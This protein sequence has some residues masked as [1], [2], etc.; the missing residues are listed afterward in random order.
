MVSHTTYDTDFV[1]V[2]GGVSARTRWADFTLGVSW[3][4]GRDDLA[5]AVTVP[6][7][8]TPN[9]PGDLGPDDAIIHTDDF[10]FLAGFSIPRIDELIGDVVGGDRGR[11]GG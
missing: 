6:D 7:G 9:D 1:L 3:Q 2:G 4:G 8:S 11:P 5:R 10:R